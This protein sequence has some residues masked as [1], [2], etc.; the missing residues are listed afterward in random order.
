M[1]T[2]TEAC[3]ALK[4]LQIDIDRSWWK[5][6]CGEWIPELLNQCENCNYWRGREV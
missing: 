4:L 3:A 5:C 6:A 1:M 2:L